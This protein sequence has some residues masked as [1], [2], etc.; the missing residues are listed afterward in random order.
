MSQRAS[1]DWKEVGGQSIPQLE[2]GCKRAWGVKVCSPKEGQAHRRSGA[3]C[4]LGIGKSGGLTP[5]QPT[6]G[7]LGEGKGKRVSPGRGEIRG[8]SGGYPGCSRSGTPHA[9][10]SEGSST[11]LREGSNLRQKQNTLVRY[12]R[13]SSCTPNTST[14]RRCHSCHKAPTSLE[15][16]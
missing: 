10:P 14:P 11:N 16:N 8:R 12:H 2:Q 3:A 5:P 6:Q 4:I 7:S 15:K 13:S 1:W 9:P